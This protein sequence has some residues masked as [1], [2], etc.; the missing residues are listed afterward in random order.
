MELP[1]EVP[2]EVPT[3]VPMDPEG[4]ADVEG[5]AESFQAQAAAAG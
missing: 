2:T 4:A 5:A 1:M 3:E